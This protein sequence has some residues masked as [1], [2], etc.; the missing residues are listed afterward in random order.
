M[1]QINFDRYARNIKLENVGESGQQKLLDSKVLIIGAGGLGSPIIAYLSAVGIGTIGVVDF[2]TVDKTN[3]Q[4][5]IIHNE[6][7][8]D[9][10]KVESAKQFVNKL[11]SD[12]VFNTHR[13]R[14]NE[15]NITEIF[16]AYDYIVDGSDNFTTRYLINEYSVK[17]NKVLVTGALNQF[18]GQVMT[19]TNSCACYKCVFTEQPSA[20]NTTTCESVGILGTTAGIVALN[21][22]MEVVKLIL[23][24][25]ENLIGKIQIIDTLNNTNRIIKTTKD[26]DCEICG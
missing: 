9:L 7:T 17:L 8:I 23:G 4:R 12:I 14:L 6:D 26:K 25:G 2:D 21:Q 22:A 18:D 16:G 5:Q 19:I 11:N 10:S 1:S 13:T 24:V 3:L 20:D 15:E